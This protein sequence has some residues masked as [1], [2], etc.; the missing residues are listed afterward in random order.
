MSTSTPK[1]DRNGKFEKEDFE[2]IT[3]FTSEFETPEDKKEKAPETP[4]E[5]LRKDGTADAEETA[6]DTGPAPDDADAETAEGMPAEPDFDTVNLPEDPFEVIPT[7]E[8]DS[9]TDTAETI[10][11]T[12]EETVHGGTEEIITEGISASEESGET[13]ADGI[14]A[15]ETVEETPETEE[16]ESPEAGPAEE[17]AAEEIPEEAE[18]EQPEIE[19]IPADK[20]YIHMFSETA[21]MSED[22]KEDPAAATGEYPPVK[23]ASE[24]QAEKD[25]AASKTSKYE[26]L[27]SFILE[28]QSAAGNLYFKTA[29]DI[30][31]D[32]NIRDAE[33][34]I[35]QSENRDAAAE[36]AMDAAPADTSGVQAPVEAP[37][38]QIDMSET[39][40][41]KGKKKSRMKTYFAKEKTGEID[42]GDLEMM[43]AFGLNPTT[44]QTIETSKMTETNTNSQIPQADGMNTTM[45]MTAA[46][47]E[48]RPDVGTQYYE[49]SSDEQNKEV[50]S[51]YHKKYNRS[52]LRLWGAAILAAFLFLLENLMTFGINLPAAISPFTSPKTFA[53]I[54]IILAVL[55]TALVFDK[56]IAA[57]KSVIKLKPEPE[58]ILIVGAFFSILGAVLILA[59]GPENTVMKYGRMY[60]FP[61][62][63][64]ILLAFVYDVLKYRREIYS[65][66]IVASK[67]TKCVV[68]RIENS[69]ETPEAKA[70]DEYLP[71][72]PLLYRVGR[73]KKISGFFAK[74]HEYPKIKKV[75]FIAIPLAVLASVIM[76]IID[77]FAN[78]TGTFQSFSALTVT[79]Q[80][81]LPLSAFISFSYPMTHAAAVAYGYGSAMIGDATVDRYTD[82]SVIS[83]DDTD[84]FP[85]DRTKIRAVKVLEN[86][87]IDEVIY[88]AA[89][90][91][92][93]LGG[94]L[95]S[96][97]NLAMLDIGHSED[98]EI[99]DV[100]DKGVEARVD[101]KSIVIGQQSYLERQCFETV[102]E[103]GDDACS[104][105]S[106]KRILYLAC[107]NAVAAKIYI[108]YGIDP[109]FENILRRIYSAGMCVAVKSCDPNIDNALLSGKINLSKYPVRIIKCTSVD[110]MNKTKEESDS[111]IIST[112]SVRGILQAL[113]LCD[114]LTHINRT[115]AVVKLLSIVL[116]IF[117][118]A[119]IIGSG[120]VS[121]VASLYL[122]AY[123]VFWMIPMMLLSKFYI[124]A[125]DKKEK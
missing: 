70:F 41:R 27:H 16:T 47:P 28:K 83:F 64:S 113:S 52:K 24:E 11:E 81:C 60:N 46:A 48:F 91:F 44:T 119:L 20:P 77:Y 23:T 93:Q 95:R 49:Y 66:K 71:A 32:K 122:A 73:A 106:S 35:S 125:S 65:F 9:Y 92:S 55:C 75:L 42:R 2:E 36:P 8:F 51:Y 87:R 79:L 117:S 100:S 43:L 29:A 67:K 82:A 58:L 14:A 15:E 120:V 31:I 53:I 86:N 7:D 85:S 61:Y 40:I 13:P 22:D 123:Q 109:S 118:S 54:D 39:M 26:E 103:E 38:E 33:T 80:F 25:A 115:N 102:F 19:N 57:V 74:V 98:V 5:N 114:R 69:D 68:E 4:A 116:G 78:G 121:G 21:D 101:G 107:D 88:Y 45:G 89:S 72:S 17:T 97:F 108:R 99:L 104:G 10:I 56:L 3:L 105:K 90:V 63:V 124:S 110:D 84:V 6:G 62:A 111:G 94:P 34:F 59:Y 50:F 18:P 37:T 96:V 76:Y 12:P 112:G 30:D 1:N